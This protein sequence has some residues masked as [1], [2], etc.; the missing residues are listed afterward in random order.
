MDIQQKVIELTGD[1][2]WKHTNGPD[3]GH[4]VDYWLENNSRSE[5]Y[6]NDDE[7]YVTIAIDGQPVWDNEYSFIGDM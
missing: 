2:S 1:N 5:A 6:A 4:G 7:G 3:S